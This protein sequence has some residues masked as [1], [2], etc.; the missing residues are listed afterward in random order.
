[1]IKL[2]TALTRAKEISDKRME[3]CRQCE[4]FKERTTQCT[5]CGCFMRFKTA[6]MSAS[7]PAGKWSKET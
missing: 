2:D 4:H 5:K 3:I 1:M 6:M 7:C